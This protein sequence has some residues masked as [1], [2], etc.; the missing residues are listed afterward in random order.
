M[1]EMSE[2][3]PLAEESPKIKKTREKLRQHF[4][5]MDQNVTPQALKRKSHEIHSWI[6]RSAPHRVVL[7]SKAIALF[8]E[9]QNTAALS[10]KVGDLMMKLKSSIKQET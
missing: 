1:S 8:D 3:F 10:E 5:E 9:N 7:K 2:N 6:S 4:C